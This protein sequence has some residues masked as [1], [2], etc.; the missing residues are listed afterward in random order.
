MYSISD[1]V[2]SMFAV[3]NIFHDFIKARVEFIFD[4]ASEYS[5][6]L[7]LCMV[8]KKYHDSIHYKKSTFLLKY[9]TELDKKK[10]SQN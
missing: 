6:K 7:K 4:K 10:I 8:L 3:E 1:I 9:I 2:L 5:R